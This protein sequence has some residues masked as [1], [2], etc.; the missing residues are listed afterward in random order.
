MFLSHA[1]R[2]VVE[3]WVEAKFQ[4]AATDSIAKQ[5]DESDWERIDPWLAQEIEDFGRFDRFPGTGRYD[6][7]MVV[8]VVLESLPSVEVEDPL[9]EIWSY[10]EVKQ[11][12][13][14]P[15]ADDEVAEMA[16]TRW[17]TQFSDEETSIECIGQC[18]W[19]PR[20]TP[21]ANADG[22]GKFARVAGSSGF[23]VFDVADHVVIGMDYD[24]KDPVAARW[25]G[26][27]NALTGRKIGEIRQW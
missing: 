23:Y 9:V 24:V 6:G 14:N 5:V 10:S 17:E 15:M 20:A 13:F 4:K 3:D 19:L 1:E 25:A 21:D 2:Q 18:V 8:R 16:A 27:Y 11:I 12:G 7:Q 22:V 26:L